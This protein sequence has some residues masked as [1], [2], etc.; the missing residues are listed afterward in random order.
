MYITID[1]DVCIIILDFFRFL[2]NLERIQINIIHNLNILSWVFQ[3]LY[4]NGKIESEK[5]Y[6]L[7][8]TDF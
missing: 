6:R 7:S 1:F 2:D 3:F 8:D 5:H 4:E